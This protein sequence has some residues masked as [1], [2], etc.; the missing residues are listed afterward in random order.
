MINSNL[1]IVETYGN[2]WIEYPKI[3][4]EHICLPVTQI[5]TW[6]YSLDKKIVLVSK[7]GNIW[8]FPGGSPKKSEVKRNTIIRETHEETGI[9]L[10]QFK[11]VD[12]QF[13]G[14]HIIDVFS[15]NYLIRQDL[16]IRYYIKIALPSADIRLKP[17]EDENEPAE[18]QIHFAKWVSLTKAEKLIPW[19]NK[20][21]ELQSVLKL[22]KN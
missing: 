11:P 6:L 5:Y 16:Q 4:P 12:I 20:A 19:L 3:K 2:N 8:Q 9:D 21:E 18:R 14:Y 10:D 15:D 1:D 13:F 7:D 22:L 17:C